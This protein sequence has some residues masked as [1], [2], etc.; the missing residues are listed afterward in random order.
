MVTLDTSQLSNNSKFSISNINTIQNYQTQA[1]DEEAFQ[2]ENPEINKLV[3]RNPTPKTTIA[4]NIAIHNEPT[5]INQCIFNDF[6]LYEWNIDRMFEY[7]ILSTLQQMIM[8]INAY[9][10]QTRT[11]D[12]AIVELLIASISGQLEEWWDYHLIE[13]Q[14]LEILNSIQM[15]E[16]QIPILD[17]DGNNIQDAVSTLILIIL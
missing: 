17:Y 8:T 14:H 7:N 13:T 15:T 6:S 12:K 16:E 2:E 5:I 9:K 11:T 3:W 4:F 10:T 1:Y